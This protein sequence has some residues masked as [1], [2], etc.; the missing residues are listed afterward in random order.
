M[1][2]I[3]AGSHDPFWVTIS[4]TSCADG[5]ILP[6]MV[7]HKGGGVNSATMP[8]VNGR[9]LPSRTLLAGR[10]LRLWKWTSSPR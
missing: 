6:L 9:N 7:L 2:R 8:A 3:S 5:A 10:N 1:V 4:I